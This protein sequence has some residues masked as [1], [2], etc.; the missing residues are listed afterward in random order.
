MAGE[1]QIALAQFLI[2]FTPAGHN[3]LVLLDPAG[4]PISQINGLFVL[5]SG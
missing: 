2:P 5:A 1:Y 3:L 4:N